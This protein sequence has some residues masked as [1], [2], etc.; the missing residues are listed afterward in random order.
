MRNVFTILLP[1]ALMLVKTI[2]E[3]NMRVRVVCISCLSLLATLSL[4]FYRRVCRLLC[5]GYTPAYE[6]GTMLTHTE[7]GFGSIA[8]ILLI[9][10]LEAHSTPF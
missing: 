4:P 7:N 5:V 8:N 2:A 10:G 9:M 3:L 6:H 1:I